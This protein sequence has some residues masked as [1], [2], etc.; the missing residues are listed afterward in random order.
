MS[1]GENFSCS[2]SPAGFTASRRS[3]S[4]AAICPADTLSGYSSSRRS[5]DGAAYI[6][7]PTEWH[8]PCS[9]RQTRWDNAVREKCGQ[10][11]CTRRRTAPKCG[12]RILRSIKSVLI[13]QYDLLIPRDIE[14]LRQRS[15][16][17]IVRAPPPGQRRKSNLKLIVSQPPAAA[18][19]GP[20]LPKIKLLV[21]RFRQREHSFPRG[22]SFPLRRA[23]FSVEFYI[24]PRY[25]I[26]SG[27]RPSQG[28]LRVH[29]IRRI[30]IWR[31][32]NFRRNPG[33]CWS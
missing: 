14:R 10:T 28:L 24:T 29:S 23:S 30:K 8:M 15:A 20:V 4:P 13:I 17:G 21:R 11:P 22:A 18:T 25:N 16:A 19:R 5:P 3:S 7:R 27:Y 32:K 2:Y 26:V 6:S 33:G 31:K 12:R 9:G 1:A